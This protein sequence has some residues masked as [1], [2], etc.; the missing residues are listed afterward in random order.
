VGEVVC[1][2]PYHVCP[3]VAMYPEALV[4]EGGNLV[5]RWR[6]VARDRQI[7]Y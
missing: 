3:T 4:C 1:A 2:I 6:V 5:D 7:N